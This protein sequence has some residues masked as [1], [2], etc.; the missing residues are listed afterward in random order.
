VAHLLWLLTCLF[1]R[2]CAAPSYA[3]QASKKEAAA[4]TSVKKSA[5]DTAMGKQCLSCHAPEDDPGIYGECKKS[6]HAAKNV[7]CYDCH[8]RQDEGRLLGLPWQ[9]HD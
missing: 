4:S 6:T 9:A 5:A 3:A 1:V 8:P 2:I 7:D